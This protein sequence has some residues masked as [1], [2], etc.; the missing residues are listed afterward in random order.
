M[1]SKVPK[2]G[3]RVK[4]SRPSMT[5]V[6]EKLNGSF[7]QFHQQ[8]VPHVERVLGELPVSTSILRNGSTLQTPREEWGTQTPRTEERIKTGFT[9]ELISQERL[10]LMVLEGSHDSSSMLRTATLESPGSAL[11]AK[12]LQENQMRQAQD[13]PSNWKAAVEHIT[14]PR[15]TTDPNSF[16]HQIQ[17]FDGFLD[18]ITSMQKQNARVL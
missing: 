9:K 4:T 14:S 13:T 18:K 11:I 6:G 2:N 1:R 10:K 12:Q 5:L 3:K 8:N 17:H 16:I 15:T 7:Q